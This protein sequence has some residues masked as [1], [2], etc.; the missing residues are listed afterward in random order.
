MK[1]TDAKKQT[2]K[3]GT[4]RKHH[5]IHKLNYSVERRLNQ[6]KQKG[7]SGGIQTKDGV[8]TSNT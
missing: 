1:K 6:R 8:H 2:R 4:E 7:A 5:E 3:M